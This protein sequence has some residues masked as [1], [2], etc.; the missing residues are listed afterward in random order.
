MEGLHNH[1]DLD[2]LPP[3]NA[4]EWIGVRKK[5]VLSEIP[6]QVHFQM[7]QQLVIPHAHLAHFPAVDLPVVKFIKLQL[8]VQSTEIITTTTKTWFSKDIPNLD[9]T[10]FF[11]RPIPVKTFL[12]SLASSFGQAWLDGSQSIV[13]QRYNDGRD[14]LPLWALAFWQKMAEIVE[15]QVLWKRSYRWLDKAVRYEYNH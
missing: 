5:Y 6:L 7:R 3:F 12:D 10:T 1:E 2:S 8:P 9:T 15:K 13:D 11:T 4:R 14:R